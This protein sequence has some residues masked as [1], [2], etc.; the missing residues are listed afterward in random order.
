MH[1][2]STT[3][4]LLTNTW[5]NATSPSNQTEFRAAAGGGQQLV[6][7][8]VDMAVRWDPELLAIAQVGGVS[9]RGG[10][11]VRAWGK[12]CVRKLSRQGGTPV[13]GDAKR[14]AYATCKHGRDSIGIVTARMS[15]GLESS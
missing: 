4:V 8:P 5:I 15:P 13:A 10:V 12:R 2:T 9:P 3:Q 1:P 14:H 11:L 6:M 7:T